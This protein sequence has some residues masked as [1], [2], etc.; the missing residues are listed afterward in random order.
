MN[1]AA[2]VPVWGLAVRVA[3]WT[4]AGC[5]LASLVLY[6]GGSW[7][8]RLGYAAGLIA[9][10]RCVMGFRA[11]AAQLRFGSFIRGPAVTWGYARALRRGREPRHLGH[12]PLGGWMILALLL[13]VSVA[14]GSGALY[15]TDRYW[16]D[17]TVYAVHRAAGWLLAALA[18]LHVLGVAVTS[19]R[20]RENLVLAMLTGRKRPAGPGGSGCSPA[21]P[22]P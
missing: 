2:A 18:P 4:L 17:D 11:S 7:H 9:A 8:E 5:V 19:W 10:W 15:A 6:Q 14:A 1:R 16:G 22:G 13:A 12:N 3:H 20:Q 21:Q